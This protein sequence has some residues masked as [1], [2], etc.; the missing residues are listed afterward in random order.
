MTVSPVLSSSN[1]D[2]SVSGMPAVTT[3]WLWEP[4]EQDA[5]FVLPSAAAVFIF[6]LL[7]YPFKR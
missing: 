3:L 2:T 1:V 4:S 6:T 7:V 5:E